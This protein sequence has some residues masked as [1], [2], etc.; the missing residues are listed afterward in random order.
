MSQETRA[1]DDVESERKPMIVAG[2][3]DRRSRLPWTE[4]AAVLA[5]GRQES[6]F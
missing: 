5:L 4:A 1:P 2:S 6:L 3:W